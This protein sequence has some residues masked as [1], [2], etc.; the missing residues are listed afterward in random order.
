MDDD[1]PSELGEDVA[2]PQELNEGSHEI[3]LSKGMVVES[4]DAARDLMFKYSQSKFVKMVVRK[5]DRNTLKYICSRGRYQPSKSKG[6]RPNNHYSFNACQAEVRWY[7]SSAG[8]LK[9]TFLDE[10]HNHSIDPIAYELQNPNLTEPEL[11]SIEALKS[12]KVN[13]NEIADLLRNKHNK[14]VSAKFIRN[15]SGK[16]TD[17]PE[18][19]FDSDALKN[20]VTEEIS[21]GGHCR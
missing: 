6:D 20:Y 1:E 12:Y 14:R 8:H 11:N 15:I 7:K 10:T 21:K 13:A 9:I 18:S 17:G 16:K 2:A 5:N 19:E 4:V 3:S